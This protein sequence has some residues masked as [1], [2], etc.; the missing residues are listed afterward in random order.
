MRF[1]DTICLAESRIVTRRISRVMITIAITTFPVST[2]RPAS[3]R[4]RPWKMGVNRNARMLPGS[5][6]SLAGR[7]GCGS[8]V[9]LGDGD[10]VRGA[11]VAGGVGAARGPGGARGG[12]A[13]G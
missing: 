11:L 6:W 4:K 10:T 13:R 2:Y 8:G 7:I 12:G 1:W 5:A 9:G 3:S